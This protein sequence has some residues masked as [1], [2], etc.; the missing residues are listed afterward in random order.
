MLKRVHARKLLTHGRNVRDM[1]YG[2]ALPVAVVGFLMGFVAYA[3]VELVLRQVLLDG[4]PDINIFDGQQNIQHVKQA[5]T[6][7]VMHK[8]VDLFHALLV[9][10]NAVML[11]VIVRQLAAELMRVA[12]TAST[13]AIMV[14]YAEQLSDAARHGMPIV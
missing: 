12:I 3:V 14:R 5:L 7:V 4:Q 6:D 13:Q 10:V 1:P 11:Y 2:R 9:Q 8:A